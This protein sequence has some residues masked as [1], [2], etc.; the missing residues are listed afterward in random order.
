MKRALLVLVALFSIFVLVFGWG[1]GMEHFVRLGSDRPGIMPTT[2]FGLYAIATVHFLAAMWPVKNNI[3]ALKVVSGL[4]ALFAL[5]NFVVLATGVMPNGIDGDVWPRTLGR[6]HDAMSLPTSLCFFLLGVAGLVMAG[7]MARYRPLFHGLLTLGMIVATSVLLTYLLDPNSFTRVKPMAA[8]SVQTAGAF[9]LLFPAVMLR[10]AHGGW[11]ELMRGPLGGSQSARM[12]L[13]F[14]F[15][16]PL[17]LALIGLLASDN[18]MITQSF[19]LA[20]MA[21]AMI[22][23]G[24]AAVLGAAA[25]LNRAEAEQAAMLEQLRRTADEKETLLREIYHRVKN[26][27]QRIDALLAFEKSRLPDGYAHHAL[28]AMSARVRALATVHQMLLASNS[29]SRISLS[30]YLGRLT[31]NIAQAHGLEESDVNLECRS[32]TMV[33]DFEAANAIGLLVNELLINAIVHAFPI[34]VSGTIRVDCR[35]LDEEWCRLTVAD[36]GS[37]VSGFDPN[38]LD[39]GGVGSRIVRALVKQLKGEI[40]VTDDNGTTVTIDFPRKSLEN[41][42]LG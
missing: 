32:A 28:D 22:V 29:F 2:A 21:N 26:N 6:P 33:V 7:D 11:V 24:C 17:V 25:R 37:T 39:K 9:T 38:R 18:G 40:S 19:R 27:L 10:D 15:F 1:A 41:P 3:L 30:D 23:L 34:G 42:H 13:P 8:M 16:M 4:V 14:F 35:E 5:L 36:D 31:D 20:L 12:L